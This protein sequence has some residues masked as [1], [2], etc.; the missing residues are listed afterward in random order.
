MLPDVD[1]V[2]RPFEFPAAVL[3]I[4]IQPSGFPF[5]IFLPPQFGQQGATGVVRHKPDGNAAQGCGFKLRQ[6]FI[7]D[8]GDF[9]L[10]GLALIACNSEQSAGTASLT[11]TI[12]A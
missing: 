9:R 5:E 3:K 8:K 12:K 4:G 6:F 10:T 7:R 11:R 2:H 1:R